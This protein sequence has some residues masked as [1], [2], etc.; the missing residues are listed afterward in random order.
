M[1][2]R[3][4][5]PM[6]SRPRVT[7]PRARAVPSG[8]RARPWA[9]PLACVAG[10]RFAAAGPSRRR[11]PHPG[12]LR[13]RSRTR[14]STTCRRVPEPLMYF[15]SLQF[16]VFLFVSFAAYWAVHTHKAAR[17]G[18]CSS[19]SLLFYAAWSPLPLLLF[20][21]CGAR[22]L[23]VRPRDGPLGGPR[24]RCGS[25]CWSSRW[26]RTWACWRLQV[27]R[28]VLRDERAAARRAVGVTV[29]YEPLGLL[30]P[31]GPVLRGVPGDQPHRGRLP[32]RRSSAKHSFFEHLL[33]LLFFPQ[34]V[35]GP[36]RPREGSRSSAST[37]VPKLDPGGRRARR[38][39]GSPPGW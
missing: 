23:A 39:S 14:S 20:F 17:L 13:G 31:D 33:Y 12:R 36:D 9:G 6:S 25:S 5:L 27:R 37:Q 32:R 3:A 16:L 15:H 7:S 18:C 34:V 35:A 2:D 24:R 8:R 22:R 30:L 21:W 19:A 4:S 10:S 1:A 28:P 26:C 38:C 29:R 11:P